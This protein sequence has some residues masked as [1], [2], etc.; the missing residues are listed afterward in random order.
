MCVCVCVCAPALVTGGHDILMIPS[1]SC[2]AGVATTV[3]V[4]T[5]QPAFLFPQLGQE[6][7]SSPFHLTDLDTWTSTSLFPFS[8][9]GQVL[10]VGNQEPRLVFLTLSA[11]HP[12]LCPSAPGWEGG[13]RTCISTEL[14]CHVPLS[15]M[16]VSAW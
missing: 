16:E 1:H 2:E 3:I 9:F 8:L 13:A 4:G 6:D 5:G 15:G 7:A 14:L 11:R 12:H 10:R